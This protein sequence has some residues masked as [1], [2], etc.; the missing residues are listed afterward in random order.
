MII[1]VTVMLLCKNPQ[2]T[3]TGRV[4]GTQRGA[5]Y[6]LLMGLRDTPT[7][8]SGEVSFFFSFNRSSDTVHKLE[9]R[10]LFTYDDI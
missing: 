3:A 8:P 10:Q 6:C 4:Y 2:H 7:Q 1:T 5:I 9:Q